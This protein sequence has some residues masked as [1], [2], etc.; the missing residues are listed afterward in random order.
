LGASNVKWSYYDPSLFVLH[1]AHVEAVEH[2]RHHILIQNQPGCT[3]TTVLKN[4]IPLGKKGPQEVSVQVPR[5]F[6]GVRSDTVWIDVA[7]AR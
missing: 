6:T 7:C 2:G 4:G 5:D 1:E 3:V